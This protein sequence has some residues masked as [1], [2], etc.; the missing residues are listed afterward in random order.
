MKNLFPL[1][2]GLAV[3]VAIVGT[4]IQLSMH[5]SISIFFD[6]VVLALVIALVPTGISDTLRSRRIQAIEAMIPDFLRDIAE[7][8]RFGM[9]LADSIIYASKGRYGMLTD[10]VKK[11]STQLQWGIPVTKVLKDF[12]SRY[13]T[14]LT[15][16]AL[17]AVIKS[18]EA[19]GNLSEVIFMISNYSREAQQLE[20]ERRTQLSSYTII[21]VIAYGVFLLTIIV[22]NVQFFPQMARY[23]G[24]SAV[25][26]SV[27]LIN[28]AVIPQIKLIFAGTVVI[29]GVGNGL[30]AG[31]LR[32]G[33]L[34][35]GFL[36]AGIIAPL[37][38]LILLFLGGL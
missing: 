29:Y 31:I 26:V 23:T 22:L 6:L 27:P 4:V 7:S 12:L 5:P 21:L 20:K 32:D 15:R 1:S 8:C 34:Q 10:D 30:I 24:Q 14:P 17:G 35:S 36:A 37:G 18:N 13:P 16:R 9:T 28:A 33:R 11:M 19:G 2:L 3:A 25:S 38:Y